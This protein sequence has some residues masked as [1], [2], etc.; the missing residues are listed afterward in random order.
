M[1]MEIIERYAVYCEEARYLFP[2]YDKRVHK[3]AVQKHNRLYKVGG[4]INKELKVLADELERDA[5]L[6]TY[7]ARHT[8]ATVLRRSNVDIGI[9]SE[10]L[11]HTVIYNT[12]LS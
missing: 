8:F 4:Q 9:I 3:T 1:A 6:T 5:N 7:V 10:A 2:I 12:N 11:G